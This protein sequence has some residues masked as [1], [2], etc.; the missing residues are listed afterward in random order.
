MV[1]AGFVGFVDVVVVAFV[2]L[3]TSLPHVQ[4]V[5][6]GAFPQQFAL[7]SYSHIKDP[8]FGCDCVRDE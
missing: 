6:C 7:M 5:V 2:L 4:G 1:V 8:R 3:C